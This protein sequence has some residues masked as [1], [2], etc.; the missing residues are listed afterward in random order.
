MPFKLSTDEDSYRFTAE[1]S[2]WVNLW[3]TLVNWYSPSLS[4]QANLFQDSSG[5]GIADEPVGF[6]LGSELGS[7]PGDMLDYQTWTPFGLILIVNIPPG[8]KVRYPDLVG[9]PLSVTIV[10]NTLGYRPKFPPP[11]SGNCLTSPSWSTLDDNLYGALTTIPWR[12]GCSWHCHEA[13]GDKKVE[14]KLEIL[15]G[16]GVFV[17]STPSLLHV[18]GFSNGLLTPTLWDL[19]NILDDYSFLYTNFFPSEQRR[20]IKFSEALPPWGGSSIWAV[21]FGTLFISIL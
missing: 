21:C 1:F 14:I 13:K 12:R 9:S 19:I 18:I 20:I 2:G 10:V 16:L 11:T 6:C 3:G 8:S 4:V 7:P 17:V 5:I 15:V